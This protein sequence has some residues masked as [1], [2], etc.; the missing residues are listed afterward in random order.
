MKGLLLQYDDRNPLWA[1]KLIQR[2]KQ[3]ANFLGWDH[4]YLIN[5]EFDETIPPYWRKVYLVEKYL[6]LNIYS[7][8]VWIDSDAVLIN[9][10]EFL[11]CIEKEMKYYSMAF[12][13]NP[14]IFRLEFWLFRLWA[15][16]FCAGVFIFKNNTISLDI[17][18]T[19]KNS[20]NQSLW[21]KINNKNKLKWITTG[22]YGGISYEQGCFE[23]YIFRSSIF[24]KHLLQLNHLRMNYLPIR[25]EICT[26]KTIFLHYWNGNRKKIYKDWGGHVN[27]YLQ[28]L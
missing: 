11:K 27:D 26:N 19:W 25:G 22:N 24:R 1:K 20:Y 7:Y 17:L 10:I 16:P 21:F 18:K 2:N 8:I 13:S 28:D 4:L 9:E 23:I 14:G 15:A 3:A 5:S 6:K 12:S